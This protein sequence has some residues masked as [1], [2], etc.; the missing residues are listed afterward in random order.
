MLRGVRRRVEW[1]VQA[2]VWKKRA[3]VALYSKLK[4]DVSPKLRYLT[5]ILHG[6]ISQKTIIFRF[7]DLFFTF[8]V[9]IK[10]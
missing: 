8:Y 2:K 3:T 4:Q 9:K 10:V 5:T 7:Q 6:V 1:Y